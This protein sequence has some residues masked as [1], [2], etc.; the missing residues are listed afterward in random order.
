M[1]KFPQCLYDCP[2]GSPFGF[3]L[4]TRRLR[5]RF[6]NGNIK[7]NVGTLKGEKELVDM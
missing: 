2:G 7:K 6:E 5:F 1:E 4:L 3:Q